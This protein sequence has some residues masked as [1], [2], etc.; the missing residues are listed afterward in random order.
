MRQL[1]E[2]RRKGFAM[3]LEEI[4]IGINAVGAPV[5]NYEKIPVAA[6]V[7]AGLS[8]RVRSDDSDLVSKI[9]KTAKIISGELHHV[10]GE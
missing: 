3:D 2:I 5:F 9:R 4:D 8:N 10:A 6:V 1:E 7:V